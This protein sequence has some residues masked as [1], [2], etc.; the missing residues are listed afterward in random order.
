MRKA[1]TFS[2]SVYLLL[3]SLLA[4]LALTSCNLRE[5][6][7]LPPNLDPKEYVMGNTIR[8]YSDYLVKSAGD[9]SYLYIPKESISDSL[10]W[11]GDT[12]VFQKTESFLERDS[13]ALV[14]GSLAVTDTYEFTIMRAGQE[15]VFEDIPSFATL[16]TGL[17]ARSELSDIHLLSLGYKLKARAVQVYP[18]GTG[19][20]FFDLVGNGDISLINFNHGTSLQ[21]SSDVRD[22]EALLVNGSDYIQAWIPAEFIAEQGEL[23]LSLIDGLQGSQVSAVQAVFPGFA[24]KSKVLKLSTE[25]SV[26]S[27]SVPILHYYLGS[28]NRFDAQW[29]K[30]NGSRLS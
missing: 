29:I 12:I 9:D 3:C 11:Y 2:A 19:R 17:S 14:E 30:L 7:L 10:L 5:D 4:I 1:K 21:I 16:Y 23:S 27:D 22:V 28:Q 24:V 20:A 13:L 18:Y 25:N 6:I 8:V 15:I 26:I